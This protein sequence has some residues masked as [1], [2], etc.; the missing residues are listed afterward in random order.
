MFFLNSMQIFLLIVTHL[1]LQLILQCISV[2]NLLTSLYPANIS[3]FCNL[4]K[5]SFFLFCFMRHQ[6]YCKVEGVVEN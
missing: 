3:Q 1:I 6:T 5:I 2:R 4:K